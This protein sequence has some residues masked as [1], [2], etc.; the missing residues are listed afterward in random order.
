[1]FT[2]TR[3]AVIGA[4]ERP[5]SVGAAITK[6]LLKSF[7]GEVI[8]VNPNAES[9]FGIPSVD[10]VLDVRDVDL[11]VLTVP[12]DTALDMLEECGKAGIGNIIVISAGFAEIGESGVAREERLVDLADQYALNVVGP[13]SLGIMSTPIGLNATF[14]PDEPPAG[15]MSFFSQSGAFITAVVDWAIAH[16]IGFK[17]IVSLGN[18]AVLDETDFLERWG[19]DEDTDVIVGY[20]EGIDDGR[21]FIDTARAVTPDT[22]VVLL[23]AG[24]TEVGARA[25]S[26][27]TGTLAGSERAYGAGLRQAGVIRVHSVEELFDAAHTLAEQPIPDE[28][29]VAVL[30]N[31]GGP[32]VIT[33]DEVGDSAIS[34]AR[35]SDQTTKRL[36]DSLP[37]GVSVSNP[38]D[39]LGDATPDRFRETLEIIV[40]DEHVGAVLVL[41][42]P[43]AVLDFGELA[44]AI[45]EIRNSIRLPM[46]TCL[47]GG[48]RARDPTRTLATSGIPCYFDPKRAV[49]GLDTLSRYDH[50]RRESWEDPTIFDVDRPRARAILEQVSERD[51]NR[52]GVESMGI[53]EAYG[54]STPRSQVV[55]SAHKATEVAHDIDSSVAIKVVSPD[56]VHKSD[57][58]AVAVDIEPEDIRDEYDR[59]MTRVQH[60]QPD[61]TI[62]GVQIQE[63]VDVDTGVETILGVNRD[64]QFGPVI[65]FGLGGIFVEV[66]ED[67]SVRIA[68]ISRLEAEAMIDE[69]RASPLLHG[70]RGREMVDIE[71]VVESLQRLSQL[72]T[73]FPAILELDINP[74]VALPDGVEAIDVR[75]TVDPEKL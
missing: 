22:P 50:I 38:V 8:P 14:G 75:V 32:G 73:D 67:T 46:T 23:K 1:M 68:P 49:A 7:D 11:A 52:L 63:M 51:E 43:T 20:L 15:G 34:M 27:H 18:T 5:S 36:R 66:L 10:S 29:T 42:A 25:A 71:S 30:T 39:I 59:I 31:A 55:D 26:S 61:A 65:L 60:Y 17:D 35:F 41:A 69:I 64:S 47:M 2:P 33:T 45:I 4:T 24:R 6:N 9:V 70:A 62:L 48:E 57:I 72:V 12:S 28:E 19:E 53:L 21:R 40:T 3:V 44:E 56:I 16:S 13:N 74:L 54:I 37:D 58:G